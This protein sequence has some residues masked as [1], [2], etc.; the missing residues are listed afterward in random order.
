MGGTYKKRRYNE[1]TV[2]LDRTNIGVGYMCVFA[3]C[4]ITGVMKGYSHTVYIS[5]LSL[6]LALVL[7][8][9]VLEIDNGES[10]VAPDDQEWMVVSAKVR[11]KLSQEES[12]NLRPRY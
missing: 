4:R 7:R 1:T 2:G 10:I 8:G 3:C 12:E 5:K 11:G 6:R 9:A